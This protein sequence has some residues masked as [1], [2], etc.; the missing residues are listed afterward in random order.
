M[1]SLLFLKISHVSVL[2]LMFVHGMS[3][4]GTDSSCAI[5][6]DGTR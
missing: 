3:L 1:A 4:Q 6:I 5:S 2:E